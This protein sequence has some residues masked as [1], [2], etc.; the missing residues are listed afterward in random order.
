MKQTGM[1]TAASLLT[2]LLMTFHLTDDIVRGMEPG[3][4]SNL[5]AVPI[6][7]VWLYGTLVLAERRSGYVIIL[8]GSLLGLVVPVI[9]MKGT[10]VGGAIAKSSGAFF[11]IWTLLALGVTALFSVI[12]SARA[13]LSLPWRR[14]RRASTA[15]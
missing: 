5:I 6:L 15:A 13:L 12:L 1:L 14:S 4:L 7:V 2:I 8:L 10:G 9:H 3:T 11:F